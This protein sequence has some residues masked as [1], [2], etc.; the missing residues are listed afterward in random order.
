MTPFV[1]ESFPFGPQMVQ[2]LRASAQAWNRPF[3]QGENWHLDEPVGTR[4]DQPVPLSV[5]TAKKYLLFK[6]Q[7]VLTSLIFLKS[8]DFILRT[9]PTE[10]VQESA[11]LSNPST[12]EVL[13]HWADPVFVADGPF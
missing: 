9:P 7:V 4:G 10:D 3:L 5:Y 13:S 11:K 1:S 8:P 6:R 12:E 2:C